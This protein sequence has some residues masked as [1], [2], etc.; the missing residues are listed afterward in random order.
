MGA[1]VRERAL[2]MALDLLLARPELWVSG[3]NDVV[4]MAAHL[5]AY[6]TYADNAKQDADRVVV[7]A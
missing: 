7:D 1:D 4:S 5:E 3:V 2:G 6:L